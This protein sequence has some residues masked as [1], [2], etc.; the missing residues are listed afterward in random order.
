MFHFGFFFLRPL[1]AHDVDSLVQ[2][3]NEDLCF[4]WF[5]SIFV[6]RA[7]AVY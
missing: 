7:L 3:V 2:K 5:E 1:V 6:P 4:G